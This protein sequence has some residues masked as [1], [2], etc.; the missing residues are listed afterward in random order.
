MDSIEELPKERT[1]G[2]K[3]AYPHRFENDKNNRPV[4]ESGMTIR[5]AFAMAA[6]QGILS[7]RELQS[8]LIADQQ[9][10]GTTNENYIAVYAVRQADELLKALEH[11]SK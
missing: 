8:C 4:L 3:P 10:D 2:N 6:M 5:Q 1:N 7:S 9:H 11:G